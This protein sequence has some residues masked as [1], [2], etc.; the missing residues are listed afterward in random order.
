MFRSFLAVAVA[1]APTVALGATWD[2]DNAHSQAGFAIKHMMV[3]TVRGVFG[4]MSGSITV[5]EKDISKSSVA[6]TIDAST[7]QTREAKRDGHLKSADFF[8]VAKYPT[9]TFKSTK[10]EKGAPGKLKVTGD[11]TMHG[12]TKPV[13]LDVDWSG[14]EVKTPWGGTNASASATSTIN[15]KDW[16][17]TWNTAMEAGGVLV[18]DEVKIT[19]ELE[20]IK[21]VPAKS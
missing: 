6:A 13:V 17:L 18:G 20:L 15:R 11:L 9:I 21:K 19:L 1:A 12:V 16:G 10:V 4:A 7:I 8:D 14:A 3:A 5:D 2:F